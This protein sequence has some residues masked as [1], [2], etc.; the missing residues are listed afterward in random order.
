MCVTVDDDLKAP[1]FE[2]PLS[3]FPLRE[4]VIRAV[5]NARRGTDA[6]KV[7]LV[8]SFFRYGKQESLLL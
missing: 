6:A 7:P 1:H 8:C 2:P 3:G 5:G 4:D